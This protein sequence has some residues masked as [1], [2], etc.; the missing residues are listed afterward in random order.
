MG[1]VLIT[2][3]Y[4]TNIAD[5]IRKKNSGTAKYKPS[6]MAAAILWRNTEGQ[7]EVNFIDY[8]GTLLYGYTLEELAELTELP[9]LPEHDG[10][11]CQGWNWTLEKLQAFNQP[12]NVGAYYITDDGAT[13]LH[14]TIAT[15][16]RMTFPLCYDQNTA[17]ETTFYSVIDWGDGSDTE[18]AESSFVSTSHTYSEPGDYTITITPV[19]TGLIITF[20]DAENRTICGTL[21]NDL[22]IY[23]SMIQS[24]NIGSSVT[25]IGT[26]AFNRC[27]SLASVTIPD[28]VTS[29]GNYA[30]DCCYSLASLTIPD[31]VTSIGNYAFSRCYSLASVTIPDSVTSIG[32]YAFNCCCSLASLTIP[33][34]VTSIGDYAFDYCYGMA[35]YHLKPTTPPT[36]SS[37]NVFTDIPSDCVIYVPSGCLEAYQS[38]TNWST[39]ASY[40]QEE[41]T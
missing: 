38:A 36:L 4:M 10:L 6:E 39:Y 23:L 25:S 40:M 5:A 35:E 15:E 37:T 33:D 11:V 14:I 41:T 13:R 17:A 31:S 2:D 29:I 7:S 27:C 21:T 26:D 8:D 22:Y 32:N 28:S 20:G 18:T 30:F 16:G 24:V 34:S 1:K 12:V 3:S 9:E 19:G